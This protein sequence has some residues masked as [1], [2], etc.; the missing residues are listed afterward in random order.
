M[1][2]P[3]LDGA[4]A[5]VTGGSRGIGAATTRLFVEEGAKVLVGDLL[6]DEGK[7]LADE[8]GESVLFTHLDVTD[9]G[10]W[11]DA[12]AQCEQTFGPPSVLINNA[13][14]MEVGPLETAPIEQFERTFRVNALGCVL[15]MQAVAPVM[16]ANGGGSIVIMSSVTGLIGT[17]GLSAYAASKA[18]NAVLAKCAAIELGADGIRVNSVHPGGIDTQMSNQ[19]EFAGMDKDAWYGTMPIPRIGQP[20]DIARLLLYLA[21]DESA[22]STGSEFVAD[23]GMLAGPKA[24]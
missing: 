17:Y 5:I 15:G 24:F 22:F 7:A 14:V 23:G 9:P 16:R 4:V 6:D 13:G 1:T 20:E 11:A 3:R 12:V 19:P 8:L 2:Q 18:A 10:S 21:S